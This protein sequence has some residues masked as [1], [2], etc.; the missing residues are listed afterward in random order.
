MTK[1]FIFLVAAIAAVVAVVTVAVAAVVTVVVAVVP[2]VNERQKYFTT[3][4]VF[5]KLQKEITK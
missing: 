4:T 5:Y 1:T 2:I 3:G